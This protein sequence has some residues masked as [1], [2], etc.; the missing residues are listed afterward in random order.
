MK[1]LG[2]TGQNRFIPYH[3]HTHKRPAER[4]QLRD[5]E[6]AAFIDEVAQR[7]VAYIASK[8][9]DKRVN[10]A[11]SLACRRRSPSSR[12]VSDIAP[13]MILIRFKIKLYESFT[14]LDSVSM[15]NLMIPFHII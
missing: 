14:Y 6:T 4:K 11:A 10:P 13:T 5:M 8:D 2:K 9:T 12:R 7:L 3:T 1:K 15:S